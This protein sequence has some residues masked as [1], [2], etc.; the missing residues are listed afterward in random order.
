M[1]SNTNTGKLII[2]FIFAVIIILIGI[3]DW[4]TGYEFTL[5]LFYLIPIAVL[6][7]YKNV[8]QLQL[9]INSLL[10]AVVW[11]VADYYAD[12]TYSNFFFPVWEAFARFVIYFIISIL[13]YSLKKERLKLIESNKKLQNLN[14]E[15]NK[16]LGVAAHDLRNP[17]AA[18]VS[19]SELLLSSKD[20]SQ[21]DTQRLLKLINQGSKNSLHL[22]NDLLDVTRIEAGTVNINLQPVE[23]IEFAKNCIHLNQLVAD[24][25]RIKIGL[26]TDIEKLTFN[27]DPIY[28]EEVFNNLISN[29][30]KYSYEE[31]MV[32]VRISQVNSSV[33]TEIIDNGVGIPEDEVINLFNPFQKT[34]A[35]PTSGEPST[36]LGLAIVKKIIT[37]HH[38]K[39][40][41]SSMLDK[42]TSAYFHLPVNQ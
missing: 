1:I 33:V 42:G 9:I 24:K 3:L 14:D 16:I 29:A 18:M 37:L 31:S 40:G 7:L 27:F 10:S 25:K 36:G 41:I 30:I 34:S 26:E 12:H 38:G 21:E 20:Y 15:K 13:I 5:S 22:L 4:L 35:K 6:A 17:I 19:F 2:S 8:N 11:L 39:V 23:Y 28:L 32:K